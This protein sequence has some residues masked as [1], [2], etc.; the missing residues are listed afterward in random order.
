[1]LR[2][3]LGYSNHAYDQ[4]IQQ[5]QHE[6]V[7]DYQGELHIHDAI[8]IAKEKEIHTA[9]NER[10]ATKGIRQLRTGE[11]PMDYL[12]MMVRTT[13]NIRIEVDI[14]PYTEKIL[15]VFG[16]QGCKPASTPIT[17]DICAAIA[18]DRAEGKF[19]DADAKR[20]YQ[21]AIGMFNWNAQTIGIDKSLA[22]SLLGRYN[23]SPVEACC[24]AVKHLVRY[25]AGT[26]G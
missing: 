5:V 6:V 26:F 22:V 15:E 1:M 23:A 19:L 20:D 4:P 2:S 7:K 13:D 24:D 9:I 3:E 14:D 10:F 25:T 18:K 8:L 11:L 21:K 12:S 17:K 16:M